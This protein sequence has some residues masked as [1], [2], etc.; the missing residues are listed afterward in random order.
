MEHFNIKSF[1]VRSFLLLATLLLFAFTTGDNKSEYNVPRAA[2]SICTSDLDLDGD[3]DIVVGH[4]YNWTTLWSGVSILENTANGIF[5]LLDSLYIFGGQSNVYTEKIDTDIYPDLIG[6]FY[7]G[8]KNNIAI[9][10]YENG[11]SYPSYFQMGENVSAYN[12]GLTQL[13]FFAPNFVVPV[14][15]DFSK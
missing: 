15:K 3:M 9:L 4:N 12:T 5:S 14:K 2:Y 6:Q 1:T 13:A 10:H 11:Y 8:T 7:D